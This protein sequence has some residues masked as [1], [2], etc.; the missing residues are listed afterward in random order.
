MLF[1][2]DPQTSEIVW[3]CPRCGESIRCQD[4]LELDQL[5]EASACEGCRAREL[6]ESSP[7]M[8]SFAV[9]MWAR[10]DS[11]PASSV[12]MEAIPQSGI[13]VLGADYHSH[14]LRYPKRPALLSRTTG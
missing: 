8:I 5:T 14:A 9:G 7:E 12:W 6:F 2:I 1:Y 10:S 11:W 3:R 4:L 13:S